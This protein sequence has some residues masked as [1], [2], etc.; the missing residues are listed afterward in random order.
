MRNITVKIEHNRHLLSG[1]RVGNVNFSS[2]VVSTGFL[3][4]GVADGHHDL[5]GNTAMAPNRGP[6]PA[7]FGIHGIE[8]TEVLEHFLGREK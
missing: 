2:S 8:D 6:R 7:W 1:L 4:P 5:L 3:W